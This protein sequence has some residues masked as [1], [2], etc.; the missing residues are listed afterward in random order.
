MNAAG[1]LADTLLG[2]AISFSFATLAQNGQPQYVVFAIF[3]WFA[4]IFAVLARKLTSTKPLGVALASATILVLVTSLLTSGGFIMFICLLGWLIV[5]IRQFRDISDPAPDST[6]WHRILIDLP[7]ALFLLVVNAMANSPVQPLVGVVLAATF[8]VRVLAL[9]SNEIAYARQHGVSL[10][11][12]IFRSSVGLAIVVAMGLFFTLAFYQQIL[13]LLLDILTPVLWLVALIL[14]W[15][16]SGKKRQPPKGET[17]G[18]PGNPK[19]KTGHKHPPVI[20]HYD[21]SWLPYAL[22][23]LACALLIYAVWR[24]RDK[25]K[26]ESA[27]QGDAI[28]TRT[29]MAAKR[30]TPPAPTPLRQLFVDWVGHGQRVRWFSLHKGTTATH[31]AH[32]ATAQVQTD[33]PARQDSLASLVG[34]YEQERYGSATTPEE[35]VNDLKESLHREG[36]LDDPPR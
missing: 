13:H 29:R 31:L 34:A 14:Q 17:G 4:I 23:I 16:L 25:K 33:V 24:M 11:A 27:T 32:Q 28:I 5:F 19:L 36:W 26:E 12:S 10:I 6:Q 35:V 18:P 20:T 15:L 9:R 30:K 1:I 22:V 7:F 8:A 21:L 3:L 2:A